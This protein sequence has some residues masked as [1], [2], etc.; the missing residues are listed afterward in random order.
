MGFS[1]L[2][3]DVEVRLLDL[4]LVGVLGVD[5]PVVDD[6]RLLGQVAR[7][8]ALG[9]VEPAV[10]VRLEVRLCPC[11]RLLADGRQRVVVGICRHPCARDGLD[12]PQAGVT[13]SALTASPAHGVLSHSVVTRQLRR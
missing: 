10:L 7:D 5:V 13:M 2:E 6:P 11:L 1:C 9:L 8:L 3:R 4:R 12:G